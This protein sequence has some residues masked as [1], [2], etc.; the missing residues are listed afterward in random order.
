[1][2]KS[3]TE[4]GG[5][6]ER[7]LLPPCRPQHPCISYAWRETGCRRRREKKIW[8]RGRDGLGMFLESCT[9]TA[10]QPAKSIVSQIENSGRIPVYV[11][12]YV[13]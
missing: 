10:N 6:V 5:G 4:G 8:H 11:L 1:M 12:V 9:R 3:K 13:S 7:F 2:V